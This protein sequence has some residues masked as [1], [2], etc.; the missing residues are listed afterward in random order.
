MSESQLKTLAKIIRDGWKAIANEDSDD[1]AA[2]IEVAKGILDD[3]ERFETE[4]VRA[5][6]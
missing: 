2:A 4:V 1:Y 6:A 5:I 3:L